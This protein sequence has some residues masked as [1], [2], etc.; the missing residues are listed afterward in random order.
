MMAQLFFEDVKVDSQ[1][2]CTRNRVELLH[3][4]RYAAATWNLFLLH[5]DRGFAQRQGFKDVNIR[6]GL[7]TVSIETEAGG[8]CQ[9]TVNYSQFFEVCFLPYAIV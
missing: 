4:L 8:M 5:I 6:V 2:P 9:L 7:R 3:L 1:I